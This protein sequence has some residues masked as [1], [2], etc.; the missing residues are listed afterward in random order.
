VTVA[1]A[2]IFSFRGLQR[3][4]SS[5]PS[6]GHA[7]RDHHQLQ[8]L[9]LS[10]VCFVRGVLVGVRGS[11]EGTVGSA[12]SAGQKGPDRRGRQRMLCGKC[13]GV[14]NKVVMYIYWIGSAADDCTAS[15]FLEASHDPCSR[16]S[17]VSVA[18][19][20]KLT[21]CPSQNKDA[22]SLAATVSLLRRYVRRS[23]DTQQTLRKRKDLRWITFVGSLF[24][25]PSGIR[26][27]CFSLLG[28]NLLVSLTTPVV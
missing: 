6:S 25:A 14:P 1:A 16:L 23:G 8:P 18:P 21:T 17:S 13:Y 26:T 3:G 4:A 11:K 2:A 12:R 24:V 27:Y 15:D 19:P 28:C 20:T 9:P 5:F 10:F 22:P 7:G